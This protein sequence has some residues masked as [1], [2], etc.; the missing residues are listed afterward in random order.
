MKGSWR[1]TTQFVGL[2]VVLRPPHPEKW[3]REG[4]SFQAWA[5]SD[6]W[7]FLPVAPAPVRKPEPGLQDSQW[8]QPAGLASLLLPSSNVC[9]VHHIHAHT[10]ICINYM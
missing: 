8:A 5:S 9:N 4:G 6:A 7:S 1:L 3:G 2:A 10:G